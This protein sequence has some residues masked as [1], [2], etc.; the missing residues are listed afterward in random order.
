MIEPAPDDA[1]HQ[2]QILADLPN[3]QALGLGLIQSAKLN[4]DD[5]YAYLKDMLARLPIQKNS[6]IAEL[7]FHRWHPAQVPLCHSEGAG[8]KLCCPVAYN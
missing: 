2:A 7:L 4:G 6:Q 1:L 5:P 8:F 3:T